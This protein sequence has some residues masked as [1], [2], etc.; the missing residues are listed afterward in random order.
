ML[1]IGLSAVSKGFQDSLLRLWQQD[2][3]LHTI[4]GT[5]FIT[6]LQ[7]IPGPQFCRIHL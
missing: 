2:F 4:P 1:C 3:G 6:F 7:V 5:G